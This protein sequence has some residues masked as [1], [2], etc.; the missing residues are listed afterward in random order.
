MCVSENRVYQYIPIFWNFNR[1]N[2]DV[3]A[4]SLVFRLIF[5]WGA[6]E[7]AEEIHGDSGFTGEISV[8]MSQ[9]SAPLVNFKKAG[10][11]MVIPLFNVGIDP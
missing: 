6:A 11:R 7:S 5:P 1:E 3:E 4:L 10:K 9:K 2:D 8:V